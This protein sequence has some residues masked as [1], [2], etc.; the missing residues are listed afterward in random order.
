MLWIENGYEREDCLNRKLLGIENGDDAWVRVGACW[1]LE[2]K[3]FLH[4]WSLQRPPADDD[5]FPHRKLSNLIRLEPS[6]A[7]T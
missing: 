6:A 4:V 5:A 1:C 7:S 2:Y 3:L